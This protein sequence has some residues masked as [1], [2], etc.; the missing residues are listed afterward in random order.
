MAFARPP[1]TRGSGL[2]RKLLLTQAAELLLWPKSARC[3]PSTSG[4][5]TS[6][7]RPACPPVPPLAELNEMVQYY[8]DVSAYMLLLLP[9]IT[10]NVS[11]AVHAPGTLPGL[12]YPLLFPKG[13]NGWYPE[14]RLTE[15]EAQQE[16]HLN[17][18]DRRRQDRLDH[19]GER[20]HRVGSLWRPARRYMR[21]IASRTPR[22]VEAACFTVC[23]RRD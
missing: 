23:A 15:T 10:R 6:K 12:Q 13:E 17:A 20:L 21:F 5:P 9:Q 22:M 4:W 8:M 1:T 18:R 2:H 11:S 14:M 3:P 7:F 19:S 16:K